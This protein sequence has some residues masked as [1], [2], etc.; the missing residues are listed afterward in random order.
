VWLSCVGAGL[1]G[2]RPT[3]L[4]AGFGFLVGAVGLGV[5]TLGGRLFKRGSGA[6]A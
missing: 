6:A 5:V 4:E 1:G 2:W 3:R